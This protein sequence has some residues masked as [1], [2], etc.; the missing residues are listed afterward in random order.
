MIFSSLE[1]SGNV[2]FL[3][4]IPALRQALDWMAKMPGDQPDGIV[5]LQGRKLYI[6][7]QGYATKPRVDCAWESHRHTADLQF[8]L[9]GGEHI[10]WTPAQSPF[11][12]LSYNEGSDFDFWPP[13]IETKLTVPLTAGCFVIFLP[14]ELHRPVVTDIQNARIRKA[15]AKIH[16]DLLPIK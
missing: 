13:Q 14:G 9:S 7:V 4:T 8:C 2:A 3:N 11:P 5:E 12:S 6:N 16:A 1:Q 10:D 15:V